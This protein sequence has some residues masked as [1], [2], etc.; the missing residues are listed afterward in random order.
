MDATPPR[1]GSASWVR[2]CAVAPLALGAA[3]VFNLLVP[4][5]AHVAPYMAFHLAAPVV[6]W[7]SR[8]LRC[9]WASVLVGAVIA[10]V[11]SIEPPGT[12]SLHAGALGSGA[13][14]ILIQAG[15]TLSIVLLRQRM[16]EREV[17]LGRVRTEH[18][19]L[20]GLFAQAPF[21]VL[22]HRGPD[23]VYEFV[24]PA[25]SRM[26]RRP[27]LGR[28][29]RDVFPDLEGQGL[30]EV[31]ERV[32]RTGEPAIFDER[33]VHYHHEDGTD[34]EAYVDATYTPTRDARGRVDGVLACAVDV[35]A[36]VRARKQLEQTEQQLH[37]LS[38]AGILGIAHWT[39]D[40]IVSANPRLLEI[41][42]FPPEAGV[43]EGG[44]DWRPMTP[45]ESSGK[46]AER[47]AELQATGRSTPIERQFIRPDGKRVWVLGGSA[48]LTR[49]PLSGVAFMLDITAQKEAERALQD[50]HQFEQRLL[51]IVSH[52]LR[53][54][55]ASIRLGVELLLRSG[56]SEQQLRTVTRM[57]RSAERMHQLV[58]GLLDL[59]RLRAGQ[60]LPIN[61]ETSNM[62]L[63]VERAV[64]EVSVADPGR[65]TVTAHGDGTGEWDNVRVGQAL[66]NLLGNA[67]QH[68]PAGS[69]VRVEVEGGVEQVLVS[70]HNG[71]APIP[72]EQRD[73]LFE[74]FR[75]GEQPGALD[76]SVGL[77]LYIAWHVA[78]AH[79]G[80][81]EV[82][83]SPDR[84]TTFRLVLPK[85]ASTRTS[86][87]REV[88]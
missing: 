67:L 10:N 18:D 69:P 20:L 2:R 66:G 65:V 76:G 22:V 8:S 74:P 29:M 44:I 25:A 7:F 88:G 52:D 14:F 86:A 49:E 41:L 59:T 17:L 72:P 38:E 82:D 87:V 21:A 58:A 46:D 78:R 24:S 55:L 39:R 85:R 34:E 50:A 13:V 70:I 4:A 43:P 64:E 61:R 60:Q 9:S 62:H 80:T 54:P 71:G 15:F 84:G 40:H 36:R 28:A 37:R 6:A 30:L 23:L 81:I 19:R 11:V 68:S 51:G 42:G 3:T 83:S 47:F 48:L 27:M 63:L 56:A 73:G 45:P 1:P 57:A 79:G 77:G 35:T 5:V 16:E 26:T 12:F 31:V 33:M 32:Y 53:N 75:R